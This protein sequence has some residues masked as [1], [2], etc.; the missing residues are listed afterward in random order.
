MIGIL[1]GMGTQAGLDFC[2]KLAIQYRGK[3]D[4]DYPLFFLYNKSNI[5]GRPES[6]G[7]STGALSNRFENI[8]SKKKYEKVL[9]SL[10]D[11]CKKLERAKYIVRKLEEIY[12]QTPISLNS[13]SNFQLLI[14]VLLS[15]QCT[16]K[17]VNKVTPKL[18]SIAKNAVEMS[19]LSFDTVYE[20]IRPCGL[21][22]K[23]S[24][25]IVE[26]SKIIVDKYKGKGSG[27]G[28]TLRAAKR[29][30]MC[31]FVFISNDTLIEKPNFDYDPNKNGNWI[32]EIPPEEYQVSYG[33]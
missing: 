31:P 12:P 10:V 16:D 27:L 2:N 21:A 4:Q 7:K 30:L 23:K 33:A 3:I 24:K 6:I 26:L 11:G 8:A 22:P 28:R 32:E 19:K 14:A 1:G 9:K 29:T 13:R 5:P 15:A 17:R 18:F 25:A 20:I